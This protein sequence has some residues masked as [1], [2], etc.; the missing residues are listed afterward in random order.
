MANEPKPE[1]PKYWPRQRL[2]AALQAAKLGAGETSNNTDRIIRFRRGVRTVRKVIVDHLCHE[3]YMDGFEAS[4]KVR[5]ELEKLITD[6]RDA[7]ALEVM[8]VRRLAIDD[9]TREQWEAA[10]MS[11]RL[12]KIMDDV[13]KLNA[14]I[15]V[16]VAE[17]MNDDGATF[18]EIVAREN[19]LTLAAATAHAAQ[20]LVSN[21]IGQTLYG[22]A[23]HASDPRRI[24]P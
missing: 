19:F 14:A 4:T 15:A 20:G 5:N 21:G 3:A 11:A 18:I 1:R 23:E 10:D 8:T 12:H 22:T 6:K 13:I 17:V 9:P 24:L 7:E 16:L 2:T